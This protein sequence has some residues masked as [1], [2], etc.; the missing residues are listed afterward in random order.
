MKELEGEFEY[1]RKDRVEFELR[2]DKKNFVAN[3][4][5]IELMQI[6]IQPFKALNKSENAQKEKHK[7]SINFQP[8]VYGD[9][10]A[11]L[12]KFMLWVQFLI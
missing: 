1:R 8:S 12:R 2:N 5:L 7:A 4:F 3:T 9:T 11:L 10:R 6:P